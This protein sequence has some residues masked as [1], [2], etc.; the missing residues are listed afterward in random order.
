MP[1]VSIIV[2]AYNAAH[3]LAETLESALAQTHT[4]KEIIVVDD[5][6]RDGSAEVARC[7]SERGVRVVS[8][9]NQGAA[10]ARNHG[11]RLATGD[12]I[13]YLDADDVLAAEKIARQVRALAAVDSKCVASGRWAR[14]TDSI[15]SA[16]FERNSLQENLTGTEFLIRALLHHH[17]MHPAAWL[18]PA[19]VGREAGPWNEDLSLNDDGEYFA[20]IVLTAGAI[21]HVPESVSYYRSGLQG[22]LSRS[23]SEGAWRSQLLSTDLTANHL[24]ARTDSPTARRAVADALQRDCLDAYPYCAVLREQLDRR[25]ALLGGSTLRYSAGPRYQ[26]IAR[27]LGWKLAKRLRNQLG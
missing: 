27:L 20:R 14:F 2:P 17:M 3:W 6:S 25:I 24:L 16:R 15:E 10:A 22:S 5:G 8:Q 11:L 26:I 19:A 13:Q 9:P 4:N 1:K 23:R 12:L 18:V 7:F 21:H